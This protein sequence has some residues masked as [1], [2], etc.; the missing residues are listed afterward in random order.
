[1]SDRET[2]LTPCVQ[3][4]VIHEDTGICTGCWRTRAEIAGWSRMTDAERRALMDTLP[5]RASRLTQRRG[6]RAGRLGRLSSETAG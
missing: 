2:P 3:I 4:C 5:S 6:G 1:M